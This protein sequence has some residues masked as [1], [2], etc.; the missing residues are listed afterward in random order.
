MNVVHTLKMVQNAH[1]THLSV[2]PDDRRQRARD[3]KRRA[4]LRAADGLLTAQGLA[5]ITMQ[6]VA[7]ELDCAVGTLYLY[8][9]SKAALIAALQ[10]EAI[11]TLRASYESARPAWDEYLGE[12]DLDDGLQAVVQLL[13][14]GAHWVAASVVFADEFHLQRALLSE[15]VPIEA[16]G[17]V[18]DVLPVLE[19]LV[20]HPQT[21]IRTATDLG[22]LTGDVPRERAV[23]WIAALDG[24]LL[25]D[26][27]APIDRHLFRSHHLA[28][29]LTHD[30]L[31]GW[32]APREDIEIAAAHVER[33]A[34]LGPLAPP[35]DRPGF[36]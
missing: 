23:R 6:G 16:A 1:R 20:G 13:A 17:E 35:P 8:F 30:L 7:D 9:P 12:A 27:L 22:V 19:R 11:D 36:G 2:V 14:F 31:A 32:G 10:G 25:L 18:R 3:K 15:R 24:V 4:I 33:L 28:R 34:S 29:R 5:G 21:L 26:H